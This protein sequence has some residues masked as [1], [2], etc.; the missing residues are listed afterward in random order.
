MSQ[1]ETGQASQEEEPPAPVDRAAHR[2]V[3]GIAKGGSFLAAGDLFNYLS[4]T[5]SALVLA[6]ALGASNYGLYN[7]AVSA[8][9][10][11]SGVADFGMEAAMERFIAVY[12]RRD[13]HHG[14]RGSIQVGVWVTLVFSLFLT[15]VMLLFS[16]WLAA[17]LF[18][19]PDLKIL[20]QLF[21]FIVP[22]LALTN[23]LSAVARG[24]KRMDH[25]AFAYDF[26]QPLVRV[27]LIVI[28]AFIGLDAMAA[29][30]IFGISY[31]AALIVLIRL[32]R[33]EM[34]LRTP[35]VPPRRDV[36]DLTT[37]SLP[38]WLTSLMTKI[39]R[40]L[41]ALLLG[42]FNSATSVGIFSLVSSANLIGRISNLAISTSMRPVL[43]E[44]FDADDMEEMDRLYKTTTRWT[45]TL[46]LPIFLVMVIYP[47]PILALFGK[48]FVAGAAALVVLA[49]S[50]LANA[51]TGTCGSIVD[52]SGKGVM[53]V[54]NKVVLIGLLIGGNLLLI[55]PFGVMGAAWAV[56]GG[57]VAI[58]LIRVVEVWW[59]A[60]IQPY[61]LRILKPMLA[62][63]IA[64]GVGRFLDTWLPASQGL[65]YLVL[66]AAIVGIT[67][68][69]ALVLFGLPADERAVVGGLVRRVRS[70]VPNKG[71]T[72]S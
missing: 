40:N 60:R 25:S 39:R 17:T 64:F 56:L 7:L 22:V 32:T 69:A 21:A 47:E 68:L 1:R 66:G 58:N 12:R 52:M 62:A 30:I 27:V 59:F 72:E 46:N 15:L 11:F 33:R 37:F 38:F 34:R 26:V 44:L 23:I 8:S 65:G 71:N 63:G 35:T 10:V 13:D 28:L 48:S 4:R 42:A 49:G 67:F 6:K 16:P 36:K 3:L 57:T 50:E 53:K 24:Y 43:A 2:N 29:S 5:V 61:D 70:M 45:L 20:L 55:P 41:Q 51:I 18:H 19:E 54:V 14:V 9:F 31:V